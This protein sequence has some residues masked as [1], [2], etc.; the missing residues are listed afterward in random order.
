VLEKI[1]IFGWENIESTILAAIVADVPVCFIG[2]HGSMKTDGASLIAHALFGKDCNHAKGKCVHR[3]YPLPAMRTIERLLGFPDIRQESIKNDRIEYLATPTSIHGAKTVLFDEPN[4]AAGSVYATVMEVIRTR[5]IMGM[6][7]KLSL[8]FAAMNP[9]ES[10]RTELFDAAE[11]TRFVF[12]R[13]PSWD[14]LSESAK[15]AA[16]SIKSHVHIAPVD[17]AIANGAALRKLLKSARDT[18]KGLVSGTQKAESRAEETHL[19]LIMAILT[20]MQNA[21][22]R[23]STRQARALRSLLLALDCLGYHGYKPPKPPTEAG[24]KIGSA[25]SMPTQLVESVFP[26]SFRVV[27]GNMTKPMFFDSSLNKCISKFTARVPFVLSYS[28]KSAS[29]EHKLARIVD[30]YGLDKSGPIDTLALQ[31]E[32][33]DYVWDLPSPLVTAITQEETVGALG[34]LNS[35]P[36]DR[37]T[38]TDRRCLAGFIMIPYIEQMTRTNSTLS[39]DRTALHEYIERSVFDGPEPVQA[40]MRA[41]CGD[42]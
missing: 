13:P 36:S 3:E 6:D 10:Y 32:I 28:A 23:V 9:P 21:G 5:R 20:E 38:E 31:K 27:I 24:K 15:K 2:D 25:S 4:R 14:F 30:K 12:V 41:I 11:A 1:G 33:L 40:M 19:V 37:M 22:C 26:E 18:Y 35:I 16:L 8:V 34:V 7:S 17:S 39:I 29:S 42:I